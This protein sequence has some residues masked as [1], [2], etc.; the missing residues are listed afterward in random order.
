MST[1]DA[2]LAAT[3][4]AYW[5]GVGYSV[6]PIIEDGDV[7]SNM[8]NGLPRNWSPKIKSDLAVPTNLPK[9]K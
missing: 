2:T 3:I 9:R 8:V 4:A 1:K 6:L 7:R 5:K